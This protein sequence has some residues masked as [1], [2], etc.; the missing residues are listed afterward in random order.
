M[1]RALTPFFWYWLML[2]IETRMARKESVTVVPTLSGRVFLPS[3]NLKN[4]SYALRRGGGTWS[5][6][7]TVSDSRLREKARMQSMK[8]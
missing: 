6:L 8:A 5:S 3:A 1:R 4:K 7:E 2:I